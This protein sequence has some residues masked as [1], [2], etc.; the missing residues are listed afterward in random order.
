LIGLARQFLHATL[1]GFERPEGGRVRVESP[2]P[3][4]LDALLARLAST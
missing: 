3:P 4:E 2:L 1:L